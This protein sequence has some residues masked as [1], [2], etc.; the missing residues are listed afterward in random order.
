MSSKFNHMHEV[1]QAVYAS[2]HEHS[3]TMLQSRALGSG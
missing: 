2:L 3:C 1:G